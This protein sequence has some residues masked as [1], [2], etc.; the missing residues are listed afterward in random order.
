MKTHKKTTSVIKV[1][2]LVYAL[3]LST[4]MPILAMNPPENSDKQHS[5]KVSKKPRVKENKKGNSHQ[6]KEKKSTLGYTVDATWNGT[7]AGIYFYNGEIKKSIKK[8]EKAYESAGKAYEGT[9]EASASCG[10][11][12]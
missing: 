3:Q 2:L 1:A 4:N 7:Q 10:K 5:T 9:N 11:D 6:E 12:N 8:A